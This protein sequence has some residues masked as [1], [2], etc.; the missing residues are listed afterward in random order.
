M[1]QY[2]CICPQSTIKFAKLPWWQMCVWA[3]WDE[4][5]LT[6]FEGRKGTHNITSA[7]VVSK[8]ICHRNGLCKM[9]IGYHDISNRGSIHFGGYFYESAIISNRPN[10]KW[11][12]IYQPIRHLL[13]HLHVIC[14]FHGGTLLMYFALRVVWCWIYIYNLKWHFEVFNFWFPIWVLI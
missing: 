3:T 7:K 11:R 6:L 12:C 13:F 2:S 9:H 10:R 5:Q 8:Q 4:S 1:L 14:S